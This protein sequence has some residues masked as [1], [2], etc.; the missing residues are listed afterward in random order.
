[1]ENRA[2]PLMVGLFVICLGAAAIMAFW[3]V[4]GG[5][6]DTTKYLIISP[7][8]VTGLNPQ[9]A[10]RYRGVRVGKVIDVDLQDSREVSILIRIDSDVPV[11]RGT[12]A[13]IGTQGLTGQGFIQLDDD[14]SDPAPPKSI[15]AGGPGLIPMQ[16]GLMDQAT[17]SAQE[18]IGRLRKSS[19]RM[20]QVLSPENVARI[21]QTLKNLAASSA[22]LEK[23]LSQTAGLAAD[24]RRFSS[25]ENA[26]RL[27]ATL[28]Q[29][30]TM[31]KQLSPAVDD[32]RKALAKVDAAGTRIDK[33]GG[34]VQ[35]SLTAD[36]LPRVNQLMLELQTN[37]QQLSRVLDDI[38]R[39]PQ[40]LLLGKR[41][42]TPGPGETI[43][44]R[45]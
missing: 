43:P 27:T 31:S 34:D 37:T 13:R 41:Q 29:I 10:V 39:S 28:E 2:Y 22:S 42:Q 19:E 8:S 7:K 40:L 9:A 5:A 36:T 1:M 35:A 45:P 16:P 23:A 26:E 6:Q 17:D 38:E 33:L 15:I 44:A 32:F 11:T 18:I 25:P 30:Q 12:R 4:S 20:E 24:M 3:W 21:D 14:G